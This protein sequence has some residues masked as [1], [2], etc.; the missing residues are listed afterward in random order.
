MICAV[1]DAVGKI[2]KIVL[3]NLRISLNDFDV[4]TVVFTLLNIN[5]A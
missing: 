3:G 2:Q 1:T 5:V 4:P